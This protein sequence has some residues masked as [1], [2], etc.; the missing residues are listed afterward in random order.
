MMPL[1]YETLR[2]S[3]QLALPGF[4]EAK[5]QLLT[6]ESADRRRR[7]FGMPCCSISRCAGVGTIGIADDDAITISNLH[8]QILYTHAEV[9]KK[10]HL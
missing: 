1:S 4:S 9:R 3:C 6:G 2:Y 10:K 8:R 7:W 5:Q